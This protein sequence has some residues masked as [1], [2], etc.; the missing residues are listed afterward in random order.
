MG[1]PQLKRHLERYAERMPLEPGDVVVDGPA[2]AYHILSLCLRAI[3]KGS[4]NPLKQPSYD[5]LG[6]TAVAWLDRIQEC[7]LSVYVPTH[8]DRPQLDLTPPQALLS[9]LTATSPPASAAS[10]SS[11]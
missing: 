2:L 4:N 3:G 9:T 11:G 7:G 8:T 1:I 10:A 6:A 5:F